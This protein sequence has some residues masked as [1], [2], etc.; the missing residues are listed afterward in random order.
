MTNKHTICDDCRIKKLAGEDER[1]FEQRQKIAIKFCGVKFRLLILSGKGGVGKSFVSA[2][3]A[4]TIAEKGYKV[5]LVDVDIHGPS[6]PKILGL[7]GR[8][9][10]IKN[11]EIVPIRYS[12]NLEVMS[13]GFFLK[14]KEESV[15]WRGPMKM[16]AIRQFLGDVKWG[17]L[18]F[19]VIDSPPGTGDE[20]LS[21]A[22]L[23]FG[24]RG[25]IVVTTP[26]DL[27]VGNVARSVTFSR[28][29]G[30]VPIGTIENM[31]YLTCP[32]CG[33]K[34]DLFPGEGASFLYRQMGVPLLGSIP[35]KPEI[36]KMADD[37]I[38]AVK[39]DKGIASI[40]SEIANKVIEFAEKLNRAKRSK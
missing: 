19:V 36:S 27:A 6:I 16:G 2:N 18:D 35:F 29:V 39:K 37:G 34:I 13:I 3:L 14:G 38:V 8:E 17:D 10:E 33:K 11:D 25:S 15:I 32:H 22:Q 24:P 4:W 20:P 12:D 7:E 28:M 9:V 40:F 21:V 23:L 30:M 26:Q 31:R 1:S 5:G